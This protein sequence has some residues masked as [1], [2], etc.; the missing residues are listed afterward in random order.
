VA[1]DPK[2]IESFLQQSLDTQDITFLQELPRGIRS[3]WR[4]ISTPHHFQIK[5]F[6]D[7]DT[8][9]LGGGEILTEES[10]HAYYYR[11]RSIRP[12]LF[13]HKTLY[14]MGGIQIPK[15][16]YNRLLCKRIFRHTKKIYTRD[17]E[18]IPEIQDFGYHN[19]EFFMD[20]SYFAIEDRKA[21]KHLSSQKYI[22]ININSKGIQF[23]PELCTEIIEYAK[24]GYTSTYIS[25]CKGKTDDDGKHFS[26]IEHM[27]PSMYKSFLQKKDR[28]EDFQ[29]FL[30]YL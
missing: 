29:G 9:I 6:L 18:E 15:K 12:A 11:L 22:I 17:K 13:F 3:I 27:L 30:R 26:A 19:V 21:Y 7:I 8:V 25:V 1:H 24:E 16:R 23:L 2:G 4:Y 10:P 5:K 20:S 14:L 28:A